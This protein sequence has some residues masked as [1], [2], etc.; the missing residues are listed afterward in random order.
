LNYVIASC[1]ERIAVT[2]HALMSFVAKNC[3]RLELLKGAEVECASA[4][5]MALISEGPDGGPVFRHPK[6]PFI[7]AQLIEISLVGGRLASFS[8]YQNGYTW[9]IAMDYRDAPSVDRLLESWVRGNTEPPIFRKVPDL[10][11]PIGVI[12]NVGVAFDDKK[13]ITEIILTIGNHNVLMKAGEAHETS[14]T[15]F[16]LYSQEESIL[17]FQD[18][19]DVKRV[20]FDR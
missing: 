10:D 20:A 6:A 3:E 2:G 8:T 15:E 17:L 7:Q 18:P 5:E 4:V 13:D 12:A 1:S 11:F 14:A 19:D 16:L 9:G